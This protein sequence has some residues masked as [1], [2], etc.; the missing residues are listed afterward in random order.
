MDRVTNSLDDIKAEV[1][2]PQDTDTDYHLWVMLNQARD[3]LLKARA[4][5]LSQ[6]GISA[7]EA[8]AIFHIAKIGIEVTPAEISRRMFREHNTVTALL[9]RMEKKGLVTKTKDTNKKNLWKISITEK[10]RSAYLQTVKR[11]SLHKVLSNLSKD[12]SQVLMQMLK[13]IRDASL[14]ELI[15][16]PAIPY[17]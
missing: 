14:Q 16:V 10:G 8:Q 15:T 9:N 4:N 13:R 5:E 17:P 11:E 3:S 1:W 12:E 7:V 2:I 6:Y